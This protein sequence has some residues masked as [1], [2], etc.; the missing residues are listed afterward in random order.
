MKADSA[1]R[2][3]MYARGRVEPCWAVV[4]SNT[5]QTG[6]KAAEAQLTD[7]QP[8]LRCLHGLARSMWPAV[9]VTVSIH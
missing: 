9:N 6:I 2:L 8:R 5:D 1:H 4:F 3:R 7:S